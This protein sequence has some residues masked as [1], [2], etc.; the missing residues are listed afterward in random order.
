V[1]LGG[2]VGIGTKDPKEKLDVDGGI[3]INGSRI[4]NELGE[5]IGSPTGVVGPQGPQGPQGGG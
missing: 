2:N 3:A 4:I 5:W 1:L